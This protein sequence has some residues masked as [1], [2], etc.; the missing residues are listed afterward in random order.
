MT[1]CA[2]HS[3]YTVTI[4]YAAF[5]W[6]ICRERVVMVRA[7]HYALWLPRVFERRKQHALV[8]GFLVVPEHLYVA[9]LVSDR[10]FAGV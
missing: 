10:P 3:L 4:A 9:F 6:K 1:D 5:R 2:L 7:M 8:P